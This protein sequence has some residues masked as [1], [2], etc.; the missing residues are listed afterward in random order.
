[1]IIWNRRPDPSEFRVGLVF[2]WIAVATSFAATAACSEPGCDANLVYGLTVSVVDGSG[3]PVCD[4][5]LRIEDG[6][7][8]EEKELSQGDCR[9]TGAPERA[10]TYT[11]TAS[12]NETILARKTATVP[13]DECHVKSQSVTLVV[14]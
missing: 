4:V 1:V 6:S 7:Y 2:R 13:S 11:I 3:D 9:M 8:V 14:E 5:S 10:G 12:R